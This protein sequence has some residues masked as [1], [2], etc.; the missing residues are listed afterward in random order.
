MTTGILP[1]TGAAQPSPVFDPALPPESSRPPRWTA[2]IW[3]NSK[4]R[5]GLLLLGFFVL[6]AVFAPILAPYAPDRADFGPLLPVSA[7]HLLGTTTQGNDIASQLIHG[8]RVS[9][10]VGLF[11]GFFATMIALVIGMI[12]GY[13]EGTIVDDVLSFFT[14]VAIVVPVLPLMIVLVA[15]S[16]V[17][18]IPLLVFVIAITSWAGHARAK[19]SQ[20]IT[21]RNRDF[22]TAAKFAGEGMVRIVFREIMPNMTSLVAAGFVGAA[23]GAIG[24]ESGLSFLGL[25]DPSA[26]SWGTML[27]QADQ[28]GAVA[29]GLWV[30]LLAPGLTLAALITSLTFINFGVDLLSNP[31]LRED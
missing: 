17:R 15:Y 25:G 16:E 21:L 13:T 31:H 1:S 23:T 14:N 3:S 9:L 18:G 2:I 5:F 19:R 12:S 29:Q 27:F 20:I 28:Q 8:S 7:E 10:L 22:V 4:A 26:I 11:G 6:V 30:W 24:A